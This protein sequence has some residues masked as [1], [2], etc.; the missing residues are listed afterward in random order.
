MT[1]FLKDMFD[2]LVT[3][4]LG[5]LLTV[6]TFAFIAVLASILLIALALLLPATIVCL[7]ACAVSPSCR[8]W[9][10]DLVK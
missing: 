4:V 10:K 1:N 7:I 9:F 8:Q 6:A 2:L 3:V 5:I